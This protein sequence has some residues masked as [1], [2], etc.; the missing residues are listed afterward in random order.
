MDNI[1][2]FDS[3][4]GLARLVGFP[5]VMPQMDRFAFPEGLQEAGGNKVNYTVEERSSL[6]FTLRAHCSGT[7]ERACLKGIA[8]AGC[9]AVRVLF[10]LHWRIAKHPGHG[11]GMQ[12]AYCCGRRFCVLVVV[13]FV[14]SLCF[15]F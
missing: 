13:G 14:C 10:S 2:H 1:G 4:I 8:C 7:L 5:G 6:L 9:R 15:A 11:S 3:D 12:A